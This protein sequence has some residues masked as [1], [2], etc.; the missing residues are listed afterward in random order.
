MNESI[1]SVKYINVSKSFRPQAWTRHGR[2]SFQTWRKWPGCGVS[3]SASWFPRPALC[4][5][6]PGCVSS[7]WASFPGERSPSGRPQK[8]R[9][10]RAPGD[11]PADPGSSLDRHWQARKWRPFLSQIGGQWPSQGQIEASFSE[12]VTIT[13]LVFVCLYHV[14]RRL[15]GM[16][17]SAKEYE[18]L[19]LES[20]HSLLRS[21]E[22]EDSRKYWIL[23]FM[24]IARHTAFRLTVGNW[25]L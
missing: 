18:T 3:S 16:P 25:I 23:L 17:Y 19:L 7:R 20:Y 4:S 21:K 11:S 24:N 14:T 22:M 8:G 9:E 1:K 10:G 6:P 5:A 12:C 13:W 15:M 2:C